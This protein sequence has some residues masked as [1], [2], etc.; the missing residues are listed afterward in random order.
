[1]CVCDYDCGKII[2][3]CTCNTCTLYVC[4]TERKEERRRVSMYVFFN[5]RCQRQPMKCF[6]MNIM[7]F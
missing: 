3:M 6:G 2:I 5:D 1:M 7:L 4:A